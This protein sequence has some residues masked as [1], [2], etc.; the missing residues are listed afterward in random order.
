MGRISVEVV[1]DCGE[2]VEALDRAVEE[3]ERGTQP[4]AIPNLDL[5][6]FK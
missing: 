2:W 6:A 5:N 1:T 4:K 3:W